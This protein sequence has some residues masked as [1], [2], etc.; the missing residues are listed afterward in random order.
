VDSERWNDRYTKREWEPEREPSL[1]LVREFE[2]R[3]P[4]GRTLDLASGEGRNAVWLASRGWRVTGVD[5]S[6]VAL[7]RAGQ[8]AAR[9]GVHVDWVR[10]DVTRFALRP[11]SFELVVI[12]YLQLPGADRRRALERAVAAT[13]KGGELFM[14]G[15]A[16]RNL[17]EGTGGPQDP[18][19]LWEPGEIRR[20]LTALG[21]SVDRTETVRRPTEGPE[22]VQSA[23]DLVLRA[24]RPG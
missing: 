2:S 5:F 18:A 11:D 22:G 6:A 17:T 14:V 3:P 21:L 15:H 7:G 4:G 9:R 10:A 20:E 13:A 23:F 16:L 1:F 19:V 24:H 8:L 12:L